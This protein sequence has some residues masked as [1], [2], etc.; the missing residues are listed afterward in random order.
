MSLSQVLSM[1]QVEDLISPK[2]E[3]SGL[4]QTK[5]KHKFGVMVKSEAGTDN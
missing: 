3:D 5:F 4:N 2:R 1:G